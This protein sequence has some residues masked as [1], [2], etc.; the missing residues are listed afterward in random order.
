MKAKG[1]FCVLSVLLAVILMMTACTGGEQETSSAASSGTDNVSETSGDGLGGIENYVEKKDYGGRTLVF[2]SPRMNDPAKSETEFVVNTYSNEYEGEKMAARLNEAI[3]ERNAR[4]EEYLNVKIE[5]RLIQEDSRPGGTMLT[6]VRNEIIAGGS[7]DY[8][9]VTPCLYDCAT[10]AAEN[11]FVN[12]LSIPTLDMS[13]PWWDQSFNGD[14]SLAGKLYFTNG[15]IGFNS[16]LATA[17]VVF[18]KELHEEYEFEN[19]YDLVRNGEWT[20]DKA[21]EMTKEISQDLNQDGEITY[22]DKV[23]WEGQLDDTWNIFYGSGSRIAS[24]DE[25]GKLQLTMYTERSA[26]AAEKIIELVQDDLHYISANDYFSV[27][28]W[29]VELMMENFVAGNA[30]FFSDSLS[31]TLTFRNMDADYGILPIPM[32]DSNQE[33]Y[34]SFVNP[35]VSSALA[36]PATH[37]G[38]DLEFIGAVLECMGYY[39]MDTVA[40]EFYDVALKYQ[41]SRDDDS[42]EMLDRIFDTRGVDI[43]SVF[44]IGNYDSVLHNLATA[45]PGTFRSAYEAAEVAAQTRIDQLNELFQKLK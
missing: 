24:F 41:Q 36:I 27:V 37:T 4:V 12:L 7:T 9:V 21:L 40:Y 29:P 14:V 39:S 1:L 11:S 45:A 28:Q 13:N 32:L 31:C 26:Q 17:V 18:N 15:D 30:L 35:W 3:G 34:Y 22:E 33:R 8:H 16:K 2:L 20:M 5:E 23:G 6:T 19:L 43:G 44:K 42:M 38:E 25:D 10:L